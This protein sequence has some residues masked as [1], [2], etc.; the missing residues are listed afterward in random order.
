MSGVQGQ[1]L[2]RASNSASAARHAVARPRFPD[3]SR[4]RGRPQGRVLDGCHGA[5]SAARCRVPSR[6]FRFPSYSHRRSSAS[7]QAQTRRRRSSRRPSRNR[8]R[9]RSRRPRRGSDGRAG[10][11]DPGGAP[12]RLPFVQ[13]GLPPLRDELVNG[14]RMCLRGWRR[15]TRYGFLRNVRRHHATSAP[16]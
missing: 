6:P 9:R 12:G 10:D 1:E 11:T 5:R 13:L 7:R 4:R 3:P 8:T 16:P 15:G 2:K 14:P